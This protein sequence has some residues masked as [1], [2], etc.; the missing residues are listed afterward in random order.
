MFFWNSLTFSI[1]Q[2]M[3]A[4]SSL[5]PLPN[6]NLYIWNFSVHVLLKPSLKDFEHNLA[7]FYI[8][9]LIIPTSLP[10][11]VLMLAVSNYV[12][13]PL[14]MPCSFCFFFFFLAAGH[15]VLGKRNC[16]KQAFRNVVVSSGRR[17]I[18]Q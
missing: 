3:L 5:V 12:A 7:L 11:L 13:L 2:R 4:I 9:N 18:I 15:D 14:S 16:D 1:I 8:P 6:S 10:C 17:A